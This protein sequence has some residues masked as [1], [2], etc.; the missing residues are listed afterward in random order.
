MQGFELQRF[1][2]IESSTSLQGDEEVSNRGNV[3]TL[4]REQNQTNQAGA[5]NAES[6]GGEPRLR[7]SVTTTRTVTGQVSYH[8][9]PTTGLG[10][11]V[12]HP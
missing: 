11:P 4:L 9:G 8:D 10:T 12:T 2:E 5:F 3:S 6:F 7:S 1:S